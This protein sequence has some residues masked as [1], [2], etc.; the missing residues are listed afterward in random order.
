MSIQT[1]EEF[2]HKVGDILLPT[3]ELVRI[4]ETFSLDVRSKRQFLKMRAELL[5]MQKDWAEEML[6]QVVTKIPQDSQLTVR[7]VLAL[8][9]MFQ[10]HFDLLI[11]GRFNRTFFHSLRRLG[12]FCL[13]H[14]IS[15]GP[16][17]NGYS[18]VRDQ[19]YEAFVVQDGGRGLEEAAEVYRMLMRWT[20][21][22]G[23]CIQQIQTQFW[24]IHVQ[25]LLVHGESRRL[26][27]PYRMLNTL[28][29]AQEN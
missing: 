20:S 2:E 22:E 16:I 27:M 29:G 24:Q 5:S 25:D 4:E 12:I 26:P 13:Y 18:A 17:Q 19:V 6:L 9:E 23:F 7:A 28:E 3:A 8:K 14:G 10:N 21:V 11:R 1:F 15:T